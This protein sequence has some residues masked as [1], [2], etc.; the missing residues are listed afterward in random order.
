MVCV[1]GASLVSLMVEVRPVDITTEV[2]E[3]MNF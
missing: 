2:G 1:T 3:S